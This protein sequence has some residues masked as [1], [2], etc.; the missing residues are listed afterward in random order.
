VRGRG[1]CIVHSLTH[2]LTHPL[3]TFSAIDGVYPNNTLTKLK[4]VR[5][6]CTKEGCD[7]F[8][9]NYGE[10]MKDPNFHNTC[11]DR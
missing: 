11:G 7:N 6:Q 9:W 8:C 4:F 2:L 5:H 10:A 3:P 1:D